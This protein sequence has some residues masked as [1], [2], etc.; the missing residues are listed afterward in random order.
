MSTKYAVLVAGVH[1]VSGRPV[2]EHWASLPGTRVYG[3]S[4]RSAPMP[5]RSEDPERQALGTQDARE[6]GSGCQ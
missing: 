5:W 2:A 3:L 6:R 4:R 1:G